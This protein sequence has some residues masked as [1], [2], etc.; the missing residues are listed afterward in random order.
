MTP[1]NGDASQLRPP[2]S[3]ADESDWV[4]RAVARYEGPLI[5]YAQRVLGEA[6]LSRPRDVVQDVFLKLCKAARAEVESHLAAWLY[7]VCRRQALDVRRKERRMTLL[8]DEAAQVRE[9]P[10]EGPAAAAEKADAS[11]A[12][13]RML[14]QLPEN[15]REVV[16][17]KFA[18]G[19]SY[20]EIAQATGH[21]VSNVG[22][23][24]H[25]ALKALRGRAHVVQ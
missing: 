21:T 1:S 12:V 4:A 15:Q 9:S 18:H 24:L 19:L 13:S 6:D 3:P 17:L 8:T 16:V 20:K 14:R 11:A 25:T 23:L 7:T 5:L 10:L 2:G 22:F